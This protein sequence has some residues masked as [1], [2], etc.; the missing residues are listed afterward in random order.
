M[1]KLDKI[2]EAIERA[3]SFGA[4]DIA[5]FVPA[6]DYVDIICKYA[7]ANCVIRVYDNGIIAM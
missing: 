7:G 2:D 5:A 6:I 3:K 4:Y 1:T